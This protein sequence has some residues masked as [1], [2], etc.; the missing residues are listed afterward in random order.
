MGRGLSGL[1]AWIL[2]AAG[3]KGEVLLYRDILLGYYG[4]EGPEWVARASHGSN[5]FSPAK[6]GEA[7]YRKVHAALSRSCLR[8]GTRGLVKRL[9]GSTAR[10]AGVEITEAGRDWLAAHPEAGGV[11]DT[12]PLR[13]G[14]AEPSPV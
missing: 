14:P 2:R 10:W 13:S 12:L 8:L 3:E 5:V 7:E 9:H 6:V 11:T 1:Q 4:W